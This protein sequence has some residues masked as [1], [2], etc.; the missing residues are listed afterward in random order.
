MNYSL[1]IIGGHTGLGFAASRHLLA[2]TPEA[3]LIW[4]TRSRQVAEQAAA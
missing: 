1:L 2:T 4:A 3:H